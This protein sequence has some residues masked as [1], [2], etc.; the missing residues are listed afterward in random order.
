[1]KMGKIKIVKDVVVSWRL[2]TT[3]MLLPQMVKILLQTGHIYN[4][5]FYP[6][7]PKFLNVAY[8]VFPFE[9]VIGLVPE[10]SL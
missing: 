10:A 2:V 5:I 9:L 1:M 7:C 6:L 8:R 3:P 4:I